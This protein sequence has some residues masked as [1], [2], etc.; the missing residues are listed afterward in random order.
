MILEVCANSYQ[1]AIA[2]QNAG[3]HR[4]ELCVDLEVGGLT[5]S[6]GL[7]KKVLAD[8]NIPVF[9]LIRPRPGNFTY[10]DD[11][12]EMMTSDLLL[13]KEMG[14]AGIVSGSVTQDYAVHIEQT[15]ALIEMSLPLP[16]TFHRAF[17]LLT[18]PK[19]AVIDLIDLGADRL[20]SSGQEYYA[21]KGLDLLKELRVIANNKIEIMPGGGINPSNAIKFKEAGF[22]EIHAAALCKIGEC[23]SKDGKLFEDDEMRYSDEKIIRGI[24]DAIKD[25]A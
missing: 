4:I 12:F 9:V 1:S 14:C 11:E 20:L 5:P 3:A 8:L 24:L 18:D 17:D 21:Y 7:I 25:E 2:A 6:F 13:A 15:K 16:F 10:S 19:K 22:N 23:V